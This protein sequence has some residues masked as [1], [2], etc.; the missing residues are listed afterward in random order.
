MRWHACPDLAGTATCLL[1]ASE[2][3]HPV[4]EVPGGVSV[5][6]SATAFSFT[7]AADPD[8]G[9]AI[10]V[11]LRMAQASG[12]RGR[13]AVMR[14]GSLTKLSPPSGRIGHRRAGRGCAKPRLGDWR[15]P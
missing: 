12:H 4:S 6:E 9:M 3:L 10:T 14:F 1:I 13:R 5:R 11:P 15:T 7:C 2:T 8:S